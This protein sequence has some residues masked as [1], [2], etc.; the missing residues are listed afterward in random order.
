VLDIVLILASSGLLIFYFTL[1]I[2]NRPLTIVYK[3]YTDLYID[4]KR[5]VDYDDYGCLCT[6]KTIP[7]ALFINYPDEAADEVWCLDATAGFSRPIVLPN[8]QAGGVTG[9]VMCV[10][11]AYKLKQLLGTAI[12]RFSRDNIVTNSTLQ[13]EIRAQ[14][15][16][17]VFDIWNILTDS[18]KVTEVVLV[19]ALNTRSLN[20]SVP[21]LRASVASSYANFLDVEAALPA[22]R[23]RLVSSLRVNYKTYLTSCSP[24]SCYITEQSSVDAILLSAIA[25]VGGNLALFTAFGNA[26][27]KF[28]E[29][30]YMAS[31]FQKYLTGQITEQEKEF[32]TANSPHMA[33]LVDDDPK[34][35]PPGTTLNDLRR[36]K[37]GQ[38]AGMSSSNQVQ[39]TSNSG[40]TPI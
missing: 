23:T 33:T 6:N 8:P 27:L 26:I 14:V 30:R 3:P 2:L 4:E 34:G 21:A 20:G 31:L 13:A 10:T 36:L 17:F 22:L 16:L 11:A 39:M 12:W 24:V 28:T 1:A 15:D 7:Y 40:P 19:N 37:S 9:G 5:G 18:M 29:D 38:K 32:L 25:I 35:L